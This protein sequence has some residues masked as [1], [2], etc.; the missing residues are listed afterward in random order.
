[1]NLNFNRTT[2]APRLFFSI[3]WPGKTLISSTLILGL[4]FFTNLSYSG[5]KYFLCG[6]DENGCYKGIY[7]YCSCIPYNEKE[8]NKPYCLDFDTMRCRPLSEVPD[9]FPALIFKDQAGCVSTIF[10][11][12]EDPPCPLTSKSFCEENNTYI[13]EEDGHPDS[14]HQ[15]NG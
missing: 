7:Q 4:G 5:D 1:M 2:R 11:S 3:S 12:E 13:C 8:A 14:C 10:Q 9:C 15:K 6:P